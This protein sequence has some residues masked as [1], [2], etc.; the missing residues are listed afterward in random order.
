M[1]RSRSR[2]SVHH[3]V[4]L[5]VKAPSLAAA[6]AYIVP[7]LVEVAREKGYALALHGSMQRD[8]DLVAV[9]WIND[10][11]DAGELVAAIADRIRYTSTIHGPRGPVEQPHGRLSW[12]I[13]L[14]GGAYIDLSV[15]PRKPASA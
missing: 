13:P 5:A 14:G 9:P 10:A 4:G 3:V 7:I 1:A 15:M 8:L 6:Y 2:R 12:T 11:C